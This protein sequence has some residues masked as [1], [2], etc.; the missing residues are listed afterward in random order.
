MTVPV[1]GA[2]LVGR[3]ASAISRYRLPRSEEAAY[4]VAVEAVLGTLGIPFEAQRDLGAG[5]GRVDVF[6]PSIAL[7]MELKV[8]G[9][10]SDVTS[11]L[12]RYA[13]C[14][15]LRELMLVTGSVRLGKIPSTL[16]GKRVTVVPTWR[17]CL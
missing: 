15:E 17:G 12:H 11:Q 10:L 1:S 4:Q 7:G 6:V 8:K 16:H 9:S 5:Y 3:I 13:T 2:T 14:P